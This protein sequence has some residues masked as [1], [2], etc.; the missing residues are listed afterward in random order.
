MNNFYVKQNK[1]LEC[2]LVGQYEEENNLYSHHVGLFCSDMYYTR[3]INTFYLAGAEPSFASTKGYNDQMFYGSYHD[4][5]IWAS[6]RFNVVGT[7]KKKHM[8]PC[9]YS[10][11]DW[12]T[13]LTLTGHHGVHIGLKDHCIWRVQSG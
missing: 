3:T 5:K 1:T 10:D 11:Y 4:A 6:K 13:K 2:T 7:F 9:Q 12:W 8:K